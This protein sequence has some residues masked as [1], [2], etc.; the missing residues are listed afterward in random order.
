[1]RRLRGPPAASRVAA[2]LIEADGQAKMRSPFNSSARELRIFD[3]F[4]IRQAVQKSQ[5]I[6]AF[7][8]SEGYWPDAGILAGAF[9]AAACVVIQNRLERRQ[10]SIV[11][12]RSGQC[13][14]APRR[15]PDL[16]PIAPTMR[17][18]DQ[19]AI[20]GRVRA[21][22]VPI[23]ETCIGEERRLPA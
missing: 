16:S 2:W 5:Q 23:V 13:H 10:T 20:G 12:I 18:F 15:D 8:R 17:H 21:P 3:E 1:M 19:S 9:V 4:V 7:R 11:H 14:V 22:T 6:G